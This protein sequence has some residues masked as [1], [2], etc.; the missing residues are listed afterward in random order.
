[1]STTTMIGLPE[2]MATFTFHLKYLC[3]YDST[4]F[5]RKVLIHIIKQGYSQ[6]SAWPRH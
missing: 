6:G 5:Q 3:I 1:M 2:R 4:S